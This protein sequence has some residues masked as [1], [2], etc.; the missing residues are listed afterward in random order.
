MKIKEI[1]TDIIFPPRCPLC[2]Q[3]IPPGIGVCPDCRKEVLCITEPVCKKCG[4]PLENM[5]QEYCTDCARKHH[6]YDQG[7]AVF[8][9][10]GKI[11]QSMYRFKYSNKR[12]YAAFYAD[13]AVKHYVRWVQEKGIEAILPV[14]M[15][16]WKEKDR[17]YNQAAMF[18]DTLAKRL[19][20]PL[21]RRMVKRNR[22]TTPQKELNDVERKKNLS[23]AFEL[24]PQEIPYKRILLVDDIYTTG[25]T[26]DAIAE[27]LKKSG[28]EAVFFLSISIG[29]GF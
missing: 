28:V 22:N 14:P 9:Y 24:I 19:K 13:E 27:V 8:V 20:L 11:K 23:G 2:D 10:Q 18:A 26:I 5:R 6:W 12:E 25:S 17:G 29:E 21:E 15:Y 4:K 1:L 16:Y 7:K 3:V